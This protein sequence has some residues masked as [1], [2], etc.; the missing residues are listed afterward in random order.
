MREYV[1][2][3]ALSRI[4]MEFMEMPGLK[5][6]AAQAR[7]LCNLPEDVCIAALDVLTSTGFL[8]QLRDGSF[9]RP[10]LST[11]RRR[12]LLA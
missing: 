9:L 3:E 8:R 4:Q 5:L 1:T 12:P 7:R 2:I 6:T 10:G 11:T